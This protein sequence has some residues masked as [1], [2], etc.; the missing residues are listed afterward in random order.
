MKAA[1]AIALALLT[2][3]LPLAG[4]DADL[5]AR[6]GEYA[7]AAR[8]Y[9]ERAEASAN[10]TDS[11]KARL[12]AAGCLKLTGD[13]CAA[14]EVLTRAVPLLD[15]VPGDSTKALFLSELG[16]VMSLSRRSSDALPVLDRAGRIAQ[17]IGEEA[18][19]AEIHNDSGIACGNAGQPEQAFAWYSSA[20]G[21]ATK[22]GLD[23]LVVRARQN[24][25]M[26]A[27]ALWKR[28]RDELR[29]IREVSGWEQPAAD[30]LITSRTRF[31]S[32]FRESAAAT[33]GRDDAPPLLLFEAVTAGS[34][35]VRYG[36]EEEGFKLLQRTLE[37]AR[38]RDD[39]MLERSCL[40]AL[41]E[42]Y[43]ERGQHRDA[44]FILDQIRALSPHEIPAHEAALEILAARLGMADGSDRKTV[45]DRVARAVRLVEEMRADL[46]SSQFSSDLGRSFREWAG[47]PYLML[48]EIELS[49]GRLDQ[50]R[51][52]VESFKSWELDDFYRNDCVNAALGRQQ[53]LREVQDGNVGLLYV[54]ALRDRVEILL[55]TAR[56]TRRWTSP[57][58]SDELHSLARRF[59]HRLEFDHGTYAFAADSEA[60]HRCLIA[61]MSAYLTESEIRHL[62]F[63]PDGPL[64]TIPLAALRDPATGKYLIE[65][66]SLS[67]A[68]SFSLMPAEPATD[69]NTSALLAGISESVDG[70]SALPAVKGELE[71]LAGIY[72]PNLLRMDAAFTRG[73]LKEDLSTGT[74]GLVH[75]ASH[76]EF[77]GNAGETFLLAHDGK[78]H[79]DELEEMIRPRK[80]TGTPVELLCLSACRTAAGDDRAA[81]GLAG[82]AVKS[83]ARSV[84]ATLWYVNDQAASTLMAGFHRHWHRGGMPK[85]AALRRAQLDLLEKD[86]LSHPHLWAPFILIGDWK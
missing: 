23:D 69:A 37:T 5:F 15:Q 59:R 38:G 36:L 60:L 47:T 13:L 11:L 67:V 28:D 70:F 3:V 27:F 24:R 43:L 76:G 34:A 66:F 12:N 62:I 77:K 19:L 31:E 50:A 68:P 9:L 45:R 42:L 75:I 86:P 61:P 4:N 63:V 44:A 8:L 51:E 56:G 54:I 17:A 40:L 71:A 84:A 65:R 73:V 72:T 79:M 18:L 64:G 39:R 30:R 14:T 26:A 82:A 83:G 55:G 7:E 41:T 57:V 6:S 81:L 16:S 46:A 85:A 74:A 80:F 21:R 20:H 22:L 2:S 33:T 25:L 58:G 52:A 29:F 10:P 48:A 53:D 1:H 35:A 49:D 78:I 32:S